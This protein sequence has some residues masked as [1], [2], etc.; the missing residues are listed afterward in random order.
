MFA[1]EKSYNNKAFSQ[2]H[3]KDGRSKDIFESFD[4][5]GFVNLG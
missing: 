2:L 1:I 5:F 4:R 3:N